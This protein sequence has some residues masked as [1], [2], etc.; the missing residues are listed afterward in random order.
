[1][2]ALALLL[3][4]ALPAHA[5]PACAPGITAQLFFG[6]TSHGHVIGAA[7]WRDFLATSVTP[8][9]PDGL[10]V[11]E[12]STIIEIVTDDSAETQARLNAIRADYKSRFAQESVGL[13]TTPSCASW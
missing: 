7:A 12:A 3:L 13:V 2:R 9:F 11:I 4:L 5:A 6:R 1:M 10:T 8:R